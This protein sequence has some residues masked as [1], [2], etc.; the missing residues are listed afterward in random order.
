LLKSLEKFEEQKLV[1]RLEVDGNPVFLL[2]Q[3]LQSYKQQ[4][5]ISGKT[6]ANIA[7]VVNSWL[8]ENGKTDYSVNPMEINEWSVQVLLHI[9][10]TALAQT[11]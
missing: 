11:N 1:T 10:E 6:A 7:T 9:A 5:E 2:N 3:S 4:V 8:E